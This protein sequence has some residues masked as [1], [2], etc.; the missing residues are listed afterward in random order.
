M[1][2]RVILER[3]EARPFGLC[4][5]RRDGECTGVYGASEAW[6]VRGDLVLWGRVLERVGECGRSSK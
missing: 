4:L 3:V 5:Y 1:Q 2:A 6:S